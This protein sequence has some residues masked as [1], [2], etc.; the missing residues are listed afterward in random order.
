[1]LYGRQ[2][3][4]ELNVVQTF[5]SRLLKIKQFTLALNCESWA[6]SAFVTSA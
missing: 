5:G 6:T 1:M 2:R 4:V 3:D